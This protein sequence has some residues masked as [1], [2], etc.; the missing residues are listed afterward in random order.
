MLQENLTC[1]DNRKSCSTKKK[2]I[3]TIPIKHNVR[4]TY[5]KCTK[6]NNNIFIVI[7]VQY[8]LTNSTL[9]VCYVCK[10]CVL[11]DNLLAFYVRRA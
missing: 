11:L 1:T 3:W 8:N 2:V 10:M 6:I 4:K 5:V 7:N 9:L